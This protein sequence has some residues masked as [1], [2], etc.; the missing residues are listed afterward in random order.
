MRKRQQRVLYAINGFKR[1]G[2][3]KGLATLLE[4]GFM[5]EENFRVFAFIR[6]DPVLRQRIGRLVGEDRIAEI[7][8]GDRLTLSAV[9]RGAIA[10]LR[11]IRSFR[12]NVVILSLKQMNIVGRA[13]LC[14]FPSIHCIGFEHNARLE[15]GRL[16][17]LYEFLLKLL[18]FRVNEIW[19]DSSATLEKSQRYYIWPRKRSQTVIP[20]FVCPERCEEKKDYKI[21]GEFRIVTTGRLIPRKRHSL[22]VEALFRL[23]K[24]GVNASLTVIGDGPSEKDIKKLVA[25]RGLETRVNFLGYVENWWKDISSYD[26]FVHT[27]E[28]EGFCIA[29]AE[30][31]MTG[32][33]VVT[34]PVGGI[35]DY[36]ANRLNCLHA[37]V[38]A[39]SLEEA[40]RELHGNESLRQRLGTT[41]ASNMRLRYSA[42]ATRNEILSLSRRLAQ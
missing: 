17:W 24:S 23:V 31:M 19:A 11:L 1:G 42:L 12:P 38:S 27:S 3:E 7:S 26:A 20:L 4:H 34:T 29:V 25:E 13:V 37:D 6:G 36:S 40:L 35:T 39:C 22:I 18:S 5:S 41:A 28:Q 30:A 8:S 33:P 9:L 21:S 10:F 2:A 15:K 32:L 16:A 14:L